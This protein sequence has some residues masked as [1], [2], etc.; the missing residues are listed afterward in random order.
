[1]PQYGN[2]SFRFSAFGVEGRAAA[3][4][5]G[6]P[7]LHVWLSVVAL[8]ER[9]ASSC[10]SS[11][12]NTVQIEL[13]DKAAALYFGSEATEEGGGNEGNL[14]YSLAQVEGYK[15]GDM[16]KGI[17]SPA[18]AGALGSFRWGKI[19][20][21]NGNC[22]S[23]QK[24]ADSIVKD[25][26][27]LLVRGALRAMYAMDVVR[28]DAPSSFDSVY[29]TSHHNC[30]ATRLPRDNARNGNCLRRRFDSPAACVLAQQRR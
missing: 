5:W 27:A 25:M 4:R 1:M 6:V 17:V 14:I 3:I 19:H 28:I 26:K 11:D 9:A 30:T 7:L 10:S 16:Q 21:A 23:F 15:Y 29:F 13:L 18:N 2:G 12:I 24:E 22:A 20:L 8:L